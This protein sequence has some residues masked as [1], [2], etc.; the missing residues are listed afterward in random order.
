LTVQRFKQHNQ[1]ARLAL[2]E[3]D[4]LMAWETPR[5]AGAELRQVRRRVARDGYAEQ[6]VHV[7][8]KSSAWFWHWHGIVI[9][10]RLAVVGEAL[11]RAMEVAVSAPTSYDANRVY[12]RIEFWFHGVAAEVSIEDVGG[13]PVLHVPEFEEAW[14]LVVGLF[15]DA[16][17][18]GG[19][20]RQAA[21]KPAE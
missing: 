16:D 20:L 14:A 3:S 9:P 2:T 21:R 19:A 6:S 4:F 18:P 15:P 10:D 1:G 17:S 11:G 12:R 7:L 5:N 8:G 13:R